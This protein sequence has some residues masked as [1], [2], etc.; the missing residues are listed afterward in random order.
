MF[1]GNTILFQLSCP[2]AQLVVATTINLL[3]YALPPKLDSIEKMGEKRAGK[4][5][6]I[7]L[8]ELELVKTVERPT[9]PGKYAGSSFRS[10]RCVLFSIRETSQS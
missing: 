4:Q 10:L 2:H 9:I 5:K 6:E 8:S 7:P 3:V 1:S